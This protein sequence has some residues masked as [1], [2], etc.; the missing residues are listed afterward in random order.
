MAKTR[1]YPWK[2]SWVKASPFKNLESAKRAETLWKTGGDTA[3]GFTALNSLKS[4]GRIVRNHGKYELG[5]KY[6]S[7]R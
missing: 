4:M 6:A 3:I 5:R 1:P 7:I 2:T